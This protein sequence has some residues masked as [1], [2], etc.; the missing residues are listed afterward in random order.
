V[1]NLRGHD[2][3]CRCVAFSRDGERLAS[4]DMD[5]TVRIWDATPL[6]GDEGQESWTGRHDGD[7]WSVAFSPDGRRIAS[8]GWD[9][10]VRLWDASSGAPL[11]TLKQP[12]VVFRIAFRPPDGRYLAASIGRVGLNANLIKVWDVATERGVLERPAAYPYNMAFSPDGRY[13]LKEGADHAAIVLD[14]D[15]GR[16]LGMIARHSE[17]I[18]AMTFSPDGQRLASA[19]HDG[20]VRV[21]NATRL[22]PNPEEPIFTLNP[23]VSYG[24]GERVQFT[25]DGRRLVTGGEERTVKIWD[26]ATGGVLQSLRGHTGDVLCVAVSPDGRLVASAGEDTTVRLW[27]ASSGEPLLKLRG[28]T[29]LVSSLAFSPDGVHLVSGSRDHTVKVWNLTHLGEKPQE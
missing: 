25:P 15:T 21:W 20:T 12:G 24:F 11:G 3:F 14:A 7:V 10:T 2:Y 5:G 13:L 8:G 28:H 29:G 27:A 18:W 9:K 16:E 1:L 22:G 26:S 19:S 6:R 4:S 17:E 23:R